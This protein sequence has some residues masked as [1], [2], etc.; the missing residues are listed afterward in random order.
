LA[1]SGG[2]T[3][4]IKYLQS[5]GC[6]VSVKDKVID[7]L[8]GALH[9]AASGGHTEIIKYLQSNNRSIT[10]SLTLT[11]HPLDCRYLIISVCP[12]LDAK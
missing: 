2:H 10:L 3:E 4:I 12:P 6:D 8:S 7:L 5:K 9:M 1:S 11:S